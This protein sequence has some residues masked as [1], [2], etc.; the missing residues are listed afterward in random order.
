M[1]FSSCFGRRIVL[2]GCHALVVIA[3][4]VF[5]ATARALAAS[6]ETIADAQ[7]VVVG[8]RLSMSAD[9]KQRRSGEIL[10][11]YFIG[12]IY[13]R[14]Q[15]IELEA[16]IKQEAKKMTAAML[17]EAANRCGTELSARGEEISRIAKN[18]ESIL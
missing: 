16:L 7:C 3:F 9:Q 10:I 2:M 17:G 8:A 11:A 12:R 14:S 4:G 1:S 15:K 18:L 6:P 5:A 13:G